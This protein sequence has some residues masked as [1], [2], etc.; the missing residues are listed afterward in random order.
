MKTV[1]EAVREV[2]F[3]SDVALE[4]LRA[5]VLNM[6]A[7]AEQIKPEVERMTWKS[8]QKNTVVVA[9]SRVADELDAVPALHPEVLI[10]ELS[11]K[12]PLA[13]ITYERT[14]TTL[15]SAQQLSYTLGLLPAQFLT[16][17]QGLNEITIIVSQERLAEVEAHMRTQP[18][19]VFHNLVGMTM[20]F[21]EQYLPQPNVLYS[22]LSK[23]A[24]QRINLYEMVS[25]YTELTVFI[26]ESQLDRAVGVM[27]K[28]LRKSA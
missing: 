24:H 6:S 27:N 28:L 23:L 10:D 13:D 5:G 19:S 3:A 2:L 9:L 8:V 11:M 7:F 17:T 12:A 15:Q 26:D 14:E 18:K 21:N 16:I 25:T 1:T 20:K 22:L 4:A